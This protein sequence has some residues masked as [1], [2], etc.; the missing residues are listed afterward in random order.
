MGAAKKQVMDVSKPGKAA[1]PA[2]ARPLI[3]GHGSMI[4]DPMVRRGEADAAADG[5][6]P[7]RD[8]VF[9]KPIAEDSAA[10]QDVKARFAAVTAPKTTKKTGDAA[11]AEEADAIVDPLVAGMEEPTAAEPD[12]ETADADAKS[13]TPELV[14]PA[15]TEDE[16]NASDADDTAADLSDETNESAEQTSDAAATQPTTDGASS[17][18]DSDALSGTSDGK[19]DSSSKPKTAGKSTK[20]DKP[21]TDETSTDDA[22]LSDESASIDAVVNQSSLKKANQDEEN[23]RKEQEAAVQKLV[24]DKTYFVHT[25]Q[26][27][28]SRAFRYIMSVIVLLLVLGGAYVAADAGAFG[29]NIKV[30]YHVLPQSADTTTTATP[31]PTPTPATATPT[32]S[33]PATDTT[34]TKLSQFKD[35][36]LGLNF[37]YPVAWGTTTVEDG[38]LNDTGIESVKTKRITFG[39]LANAEIRITPTSWTSSLKSPLVTPLDDAQFTANSTSPLAAPNLSISTTDD[40]YVIMAYA[41]SDKSVQLQAAKKLSLRLLNAQYVEF[42]AKPVTGTAAQTCTTAAKTST[43]TATRLP[44]RACYTDADIKDVQNVVASLKAS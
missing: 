3:V 4:Q 31:A 33:T 1:A 39:S 9:L 28:A 16:S 40:S 38:P 23:K 10:D 25:G 20:D 5:T 21:K 32:P 29:S 42:Y 17:T 19:S 13:E 18:A 6:Q 37:S 15:L 43:G 7:K 24:D 36:T 8:K 26:P 11:D 22:P 27:K 2:T 34:A 44:G 14:L 12:P 41:T 30:P 35:A